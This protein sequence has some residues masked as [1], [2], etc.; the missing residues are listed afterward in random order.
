MLTQS[1]ENYL[2]AIFAL[3]E[4]QTEIVSTNLLSEKMKTK[5]SSVTDMLRKLADKSFVS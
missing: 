5:P 2:K 1:E 3:S 4:Q